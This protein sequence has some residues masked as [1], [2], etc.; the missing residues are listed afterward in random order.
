MWDVAR[1]TPLKV[2]GNICSIEKSA[3]KMGAFYL[4]H[5]FN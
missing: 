2:F 1:M 4:L 5:Y 3:E